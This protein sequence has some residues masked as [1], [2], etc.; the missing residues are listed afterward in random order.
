MRLFIIWFHQQTVEVGRSNL[1][2]VEIGGRKFYHGATHGGVYGPVGSV[3]D[4]RRN[5]QHVT[6]LQQRRFSQLDLKGKFPLGYEDQF[7]IGVDM[8]AWMGG[9]TPLFLKNV[10]YFLCAGSGKLGFGFDERLHGT[11]P[12]L[13][14]L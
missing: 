6:G 3:G 4:E 5:K 11:S 10:V 1:G 12:P 8:V 2:G 7:I 13:L 14:L 9:G